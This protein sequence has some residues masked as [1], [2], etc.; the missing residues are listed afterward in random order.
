MLVNLLV[1]GGSLPNL[2]LSHIHILAVLQGLYHSLIQMVSFDIELM[3][4]VVLVEIHHFLQD[5]SL[6]KLL[7][8]G[9]FV[10][11]RFAHRCANL[12]VARIIQLFLS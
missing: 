2:L 6:I 4:E 5:F 1:I 9:F 3:K 8:R 7:T 11:V 10:K 12:D